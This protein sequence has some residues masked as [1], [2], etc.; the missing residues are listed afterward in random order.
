MFKFLKQLFF[1]DT[2]ALDF[3]QAKFRNLY[4]CVDSFFHKQSV[5][6]FFVFC[7]CKVF[8]DYLKQEKRQTIRNKPWDSANKT[9]IKD[10]TSQLLAYLLFKQ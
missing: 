7:S 3:K 5:S 10:T 2:G 9:I 6:F 4:I 1:S 8:I